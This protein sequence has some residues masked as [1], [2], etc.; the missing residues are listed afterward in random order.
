VRLEVEITLNINH[1]EYP[2]K[3]P[4]SETLLNTLRRLGFFSV[5]SGECK[6][7]ECGACTILF[8]GKP[9]NSCSMLTAHAEGHL[10]QT[11]ESLG[12]HPDQGW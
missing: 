9:V 6:T 3:V 11:V 5:K 12:E 7:G 8:D 4:A 1:Q 10:I 2:L